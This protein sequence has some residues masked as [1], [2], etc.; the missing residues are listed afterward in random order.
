MLNIIVGEQDINDGG[1]NSIFRANYEDVWFDDPFVK[2]IVMEIDESEVVS[3][4]LIISPV[5]GAISSERISG[6][7]KVLIMLLKEPETPQWGSSCGDNCMDLMLEIS[8]LH[9]VTVK[10]SHCPGY[11]PEDA[12][13]RFLDN[14]ELVFGCAALQLGIINRLRP[15]TRG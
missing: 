7:S 8:K 12:E 10:F 5:L 2:R 1:I 9:D 3:A 11:F 4:N 14:G 15:G 6:G 13:A